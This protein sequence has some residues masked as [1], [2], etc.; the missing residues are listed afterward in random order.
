VDWWTAGHGTDLPVVTF[1]ASTGAAAALVTAAE[2]SAVV[3]VVSRGGRPDL[4]GS[5]LGHVGVPVLLVVGGQDHQV[6]DLNRRA[7]AKIT[8]PVELAVVPGATHLFEEPGTLEEVVRLTVEALD[9]WLGP[10][11][12]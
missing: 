10:P 8:G 5:A 1:G 6:L 7:A 9:R 4:A 12:A 2:R 11:A 3:G